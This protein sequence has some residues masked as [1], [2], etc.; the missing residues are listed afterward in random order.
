[1]LSGRA[2]ALELSYPPIASSSQ[3]IMEEGFREFAESLVQNID[4]VFFWRDGVTLT[5]YFVSH[6]F[7][8]IFDRPCSSAYLEPS[9]WIEAIH[10]DDREEAIQ[11]FKRASASAETQVE[12]RI[13]RPNGEVRWLWVRTFPA[14]GAGSSR[15]LIGIAQDCTERVKAEE[16]Q[17]FLAAIVQSSDDSIIGTDLDGRVVSWNHGAEKLFGYSAEE[18]I[19]NEVT[20]L[21]APGSR[22][23][24]WS[25]LEKIRRKEPIER[26][27][28]VRFAKGG[29][30]ID[31]SV[32]LSPI[33]NK[34]GQLLGVSAIYRDIT[35][36]KVAS[37][38]LLKAKDAAEVANRAKSEF[39]ANMSHEI[40]T[41]M[42]G[43][44]GM[45]EV[46]L[47]TD[48]SDEQRE[49]VD[50]VQYSAQGLLEI[51]NNILDFSKLDAKKLELEQRQFHPEDVVDTIL[52]EMGVQAKKK[53]LVLTANVAPDIPSVLVGDPVRLRQ[54]LSNLIGNAIKFTRAGGVDV[55]VSQVSTGLLHVSVTDTGIGIASEKQAM[56]FD[57]FTQVDGSVR[58]EVGGNGLGLT[59]VSRLVQMMGGRIWVDSDGSSGSVFHFTAQFGVA[60]T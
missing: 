29:K 23:D 13:V 35:Q 5:P 54:I 20:L 2:E 50:I 40:R 52:H 34:S 15:T 31:V 60:L 43:V 6:S 9:S 19:G 14:P 8:R 16:T 42:N 39:L 1:M 27:E 24:C 38:Q 46:L 22:G 45:A 59:I 58:R 56:I 17:A 30:A 41:P 7:E 10:P 33:Q 18:T 26:F 49:Y 36:Q 21:F 32:F 11:H 57:A 28:S 3:S 48:L 55:S 51:I 47:E 25:V 12:Y 53:D 44:L 4:E 37:A